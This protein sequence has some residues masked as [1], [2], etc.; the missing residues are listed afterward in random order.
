M[1]FYAHTVE[2]GQDME[3]HSEPERDAYMT[4][5][6]HR[7]FTVILSEGS[8]E[9]EEDALGL[10]PE[11]YRVAMAN[12]RLR[13]K[14]LLEDSTLSNDEKVRAILDVMSEEPE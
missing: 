12:F 2:T 1:M 10:T 14:A 4:E 7:G 5:A 11:D 3:F 8:T 9:P 6:L 13:F